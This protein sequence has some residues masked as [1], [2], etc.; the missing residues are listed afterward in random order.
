MKKDSLSLCGASVCGGAT[1]DRPDYTT[2][3]PWLDCDLAG[4]VTE[5]TGGSLKDHFALAVNKERILKIEIPE[6]YA[7]GGTMMDLKLQNVED[8]KKMFLG[9]APTEHDAKLAYDLFWLMMDWEGR[10]ALGIAPLKQVTDRIEAIDNVDA[11]TAY[12]LE[13]PPEKRLTTLWDVSP[14]GDL[15]DSAHYILAFAW[16][17]T[18]FLLKDSAE[19]SKLTDYGKIKKEA[20]TALAYALSVLNAF[21]DE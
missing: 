10:N 5:A 14:T 11:L 8:T 16:N 2:G 13:I 19:Y 15:K 1:L 6:G 20:V 18:Q 4:N 9:K 21:A 17:E 3:T 7:Y 12:F